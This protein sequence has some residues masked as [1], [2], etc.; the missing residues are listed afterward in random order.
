[1]LGSD[2]KDVKGLLQFFLVQHLMYIPFNP[3]PVIFA[4]RRPRVKQMQLPRANKDMEVAPE[5]SQQNLEFSFPVGTQYH[6]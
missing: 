6:F 4:L 3:F 2:E 1:M 5:A